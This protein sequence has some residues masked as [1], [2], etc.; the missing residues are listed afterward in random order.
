LF[1]GCSAAGNLK[2]H[3]YRGFISQNQE[4]FSAICR[5]RKE[6]MN[7]SGMNDALR[8]EKLLPADKSFHIQVQ[9]GI[10]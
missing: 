7:N 9:A 2:K 6:S 5:Y 8:R 10:I 4:K 3:P 1:F